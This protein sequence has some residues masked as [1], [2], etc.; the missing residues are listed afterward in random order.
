[1]PEAGKSGIH[2][3]DGIMPSRPLAPI[4]PPSDL[5]PVRVTVSYRWF[6]GTLLNGIIGVA[7]MGG[8]LYAAIDGQTKF[9]IEPTFALANAA[10]NGP[11]DNKSDKYAST[12][13]QAVH[14]IIH[15]SNTRLLGTK[16]FIEVK[17]YARV[18][19]QLSLTDRSKQPACPNLIH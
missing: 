6:T 8:A 1:M 15:E 16:E 5:S 4:A 14:L 17:R 3:D 2:S 12:D 9:A 18:A 19:A 10:T 11:V 13:N 7:L